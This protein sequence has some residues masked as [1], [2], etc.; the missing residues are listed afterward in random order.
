MKKLVSVLIVNYN[1]QKYLKRCIQSVINQNYNSKEIIVVDDFSQDNSV[2]I[3]KNFKK[4][5]KFMVNKKRTK[6]GSY[7]QMQCFHKAFKKCKGEIIFFLDSD[8][9][10]KKNKLSRIVKF[11]NRNDDEKIV[12]DLPIFKFQNKIIKKKFKQKTM[13]F[14][15]WPRFSPQSCICVRKN[16]A[17]ELFK[18]LK[19]FKY[20][21]IWFD[22]RI[23]AYT[24]L[25]YQKLPHV[26]DYLTYYQQN[27]NSA[28]KEFNFFSN[29]WWKRR[30][31]AHEFLSFISK[32]TKTKNL[33]SLDY[34]ITKI[35]INLFNLK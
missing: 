29:K 33:V 24:Y 7:N 34:I 9:Y 5:I 18:N 21:D 12:F 6:I 8:D 19:F 20:K 11:M 1:N 23:A 27:E 30:N 2:E 17:L 22:F 14:S 10:F 32:K 26:K 25:K 16:Y 35:Y 31:E 28:S 15:N 13:L 3:L 4:D